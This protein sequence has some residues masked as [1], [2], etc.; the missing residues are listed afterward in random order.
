MAEKRIVE[1]TGRGVVC[2]ISNY[3]WLDGLSFTAMRER[4]LEVFDQI[5]VDNLHG[6]R[7]ISEYA[8]DGRTSETIFAVRGTSPGIKIGTAICLLSATT[9]NEKLRNCSVFY[10]DFDDAD[11]ADRRIHLLASIGQ[12]KVSL[13]YQKLRPVLELGLP[14]K[15]MLAATTYLDWPLLPEIFPISY[16]G[17][18]TSRDDLLVDVSRAKLLGR[19]EDY[20][21]EKIGHAEMRRAVPTAMRH[22]ARFQAETTRDYLR[23]RGFLPKT[24]LATCIDPSICGGSTGNPKR[25]SWTK[26]EQN[27]SP[28]PDRIIFGWQQHRRTAEISTHPLL[29]HYSAH[30]M[31]SNGGRTYSHCMLLALKDLCCTRKNNTKERGTLARA[32]SLTWTRY[33]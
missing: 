5:W 7:K 2:F 25:S 33:R 20:F 12:S 18:Q 4:Y 23:K 9:A 13:K 28:R 31:L 24:S 3:S 6:D 1:K 30:A 15:P 27:I 11:A 19:M 16:P 22:T 26:N 17:V 29:A 8:P 14:L 32:E 21:D 10:R